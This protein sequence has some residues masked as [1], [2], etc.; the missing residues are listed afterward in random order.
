MEA[1]SQEK[2][3][4]EPGKMPSSIISSYHLQELAS[5]FYLTDQC[6]F[7]F[8]Q[9]QHK[10]NEVIEA[11]LPPSN[12]FSGDNF[13]EKLSELDT[14]ESLVL[15]SNHNRK[16]PRKIS[17]IPTPSESSQNTK[18]M[19]I[20]SSE[21]KQSCGLISDSY[22][23]ILSN[24]KRITWTKDLHEH[25]VECVNRLGGSEKA[26]PKAIL[27]LM[28]SKELSI[29][30]VKSHL[31][32]YRSEKLISDQ[33]LQGFPEKTVCINDIPQLYMKMSMQIREALQLQLELEKHLHDQLEAC[34]SIEL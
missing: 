22:R 16:F 15:S 7:G 19:S 30:Q 23:H 11:S 14:L 28:K 33:S 5:A 18:N 17:S 9:N 13:S 21:E 10:N 4:L 8:H 20:F 1:Q 26:T 24:K 6:F 32:K 25:F 34:T 12:Q 29:L 2:Q 3:N 27:K 31:Q